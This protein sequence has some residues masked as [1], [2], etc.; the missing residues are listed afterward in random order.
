MLLPCL[1]TQLKLPLS[2]KLCFQQFTLFCAIISKHTSNLNP[3]PT[4]A[5][6]NS[7]GWICGRFSWLFSGRMLLHT[8]KCLSRSDPAWSVL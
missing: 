5:R 4:E 1:T 2:T 7:E 8:L 6:P 3:P